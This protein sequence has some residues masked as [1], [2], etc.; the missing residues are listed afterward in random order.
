[1]AGMEE[2]QRDS[3]RVILGSE[4]QPLVAAGI[5]DRKLRR[6]ILTIA[7][8]DPSFEQS[9]APAPAESQE[10]ADE[11]PSAGAESHEPAAAL[12]AGET[13]AIPEAAPAVSE[14]HEQSV[15]AE[16]GAAVAAATNE[17]RTE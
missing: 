8:G 2:E 6:R 4:L 5:V 12:S 13:D 14:E 15:S 3:A 9:A 7:T 17:T 1:M 16:D 11:A 10:A